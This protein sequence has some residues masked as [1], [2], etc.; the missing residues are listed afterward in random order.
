MDRMARFDINVHLGERSYPIIVEAGILG[1]IEKNI[2]P[3]ISSRKCL[4]VTDS[5]VSELYE[6]KVVS[7]LKSAGADVAVSKFQAG[8]AQKHL[9][10][11]MG[12]YHDA[13]TAG[14][15]RS[16][17]IIALGG[18][19]PGDIAG[20]TAA[21]YMRG[22]KFIQIP[23]SLLAM[24]DSSVGGKTGVDLP[25]GKNLVG[26]FWQ[27]EMVVVDPELL[28]TLPRRELL[29]GLAEVVKYAVIMDAEFLDLLEANIDK[30]L[31]LDLEFYSQIV[32]HCCKCKADIVR[33]DERE[34]GIRAI[35]NYGHT[36]GHAVE[37]VAGFGVVE[38]GEGVAIG[39]AMAADVAVAMGMVDQSMADR[40][41][42]LLKA[43]G[44]P[45]DVADVTPE[46]LLVAMGSDKKK[47]GSKKKFVLP[48]KL[49]KASIFDNVEDSMLLEIMAK[50]CR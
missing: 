9:E 6:E 18:G 3:M 35:L 32:S 36:F 47:E 19:V 30:L 4:I 5:N 7:V 10:T 14:L 17:Y 13:V 29:C 33:Q 27:P 41:E 23:S 45:V 48:E 12:I 8:E 20:F 15:D 2:A 26:A 25:E 21:T 1:S 24:V 38:H 39:M 37:A 43:I 50:R 22:I 49:G 28:I 46:Q 44:L 16:S 31:A 34:G 11:M 42:K 40:Q